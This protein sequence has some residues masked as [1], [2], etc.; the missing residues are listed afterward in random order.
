MVEKAERQQ[1]ALLEDVRRMISEAQN[2]NPSATAE[3]ETET[4][5]QIEE[6]AS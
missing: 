5:K 4:V 1:A 3:Q 6:Q 2:L